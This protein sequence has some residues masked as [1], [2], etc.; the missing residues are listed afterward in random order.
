MKP[1]PLLRSALPD[2]LV[3]YP[4]S[5]RV[6]NP[7]IDDAS[8]TE[9]IKTQQISAT[10]GNNKSKEKPPQTKAKKEPKEKPEDD[11]QLDLF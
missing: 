8:V 3:A 4:M 2:D 6:N 1:C 9:P 5:N 11:T 10:D 7:S